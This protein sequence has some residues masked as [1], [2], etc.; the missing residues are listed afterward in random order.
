MSRVMRMFTGCSPTKQAKGI[1]LVTMMVDSLS[2]M[3]FTTDLMGG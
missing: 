1:G 2:M 3:S